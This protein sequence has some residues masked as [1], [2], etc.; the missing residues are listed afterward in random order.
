MS[1][2]TTLYV[3]IYRV[4]CC[5][6][7][8][9]LFEFCVCFCL[10]CCVC[11]SARTVHCYIYIYIYSLFSFRRNMFFLAI[12]SYMRQTGGGSRLVEGGGGDKQLMK[13]MKTPSYSIYIPCIQSCNKKI[14]IVLK[15]Y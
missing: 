3:F 14:I 4:S 10:F 15:A 1:I 9:M 7:A 2:N 8:W 13:I 6:L 11:C 12:T 5:L